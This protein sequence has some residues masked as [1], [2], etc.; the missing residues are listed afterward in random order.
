MKNCSILNCKMKYA[1]MSRMEDDMSK[2]IKT[3]VTWPADLLDKLR[4][5]ARRRRLDSLSRMAEIALYEWLDGRPT[6]PPVK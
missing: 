4:E 6:P 1:K 5:E 2:R 3:S